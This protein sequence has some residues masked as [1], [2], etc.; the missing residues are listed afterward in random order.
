MTSESLDKLIEELKSPDPARSTLDIYEFITEHRTMAVYQYNNFIKIFEDFFDE[1][2][3]V[4]GLLNYSP[5]SNWPKH[6]SIQ[7][8]L[9][10]ETL[11]TLHCSFEIAINGYYYESVML[12][13]SVFE[14]YLRMVFISCS[15]SDWESAFYDLKGRRR[16]DVTSL[17]RDH[18]KVDWHFI[19]RLMCKTSHSKSHYHLKKIIDR[20]KNPKQLIQLEYKG[21]KKVLQFAINCIMLDLALLFHTMMT[22][23]E[24]DFDKLSDLK[25]MK[26]RLKKIDEALLDIIRANERSKFSAITNDI[27]KIEKIM[28]VADL[29]KDWS[30]LA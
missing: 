26:S 17:I 30:G 1:L 8:S 23:F 14:T 21:D 24:P 9:Y 4:I 11:K 15:P 7:Y 19:Y 22:L 29:G 13:R 18:L 12:S 20:S 5:K 10:P 27:L 2:N 25:K 3:A 28:R 16:F 6:R